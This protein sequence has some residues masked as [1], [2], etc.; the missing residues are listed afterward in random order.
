VEATDR[1]GFFRK[2]LA[3]RMISFRRDIYRPLQLA[4]EVCRLLEV[5]DQFETSAVRALGFSVAEISLQGVF[6]VSKR[7]DLCFWGCS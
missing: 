7:H 4:G 2:L 3:T 6:L 1:S 5:S